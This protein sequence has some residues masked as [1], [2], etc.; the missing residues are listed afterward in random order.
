[1]QSKRR[2]GNATC[3]GTLS[4]AQSLTKLPQMSPLVNHSQRC[5]NTFFHKCKS[6]IQNF[7]MITDYCRK[8][9]L[10]LTYQFTLLW[11]RLLAQQF[12]SKIRKVYDLKFCSMWNPCAPSIP[13]LKTG[14]NRYLSEIRKV[15]FSNH[16]AIVQWSVIF[17]NLLN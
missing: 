12:F 15:P 2:I 3:G 16:R 9:A 11:N 10:H 17:V 4:H 1:M 14:L 13:S 5:T 6:S 7:A 8:S